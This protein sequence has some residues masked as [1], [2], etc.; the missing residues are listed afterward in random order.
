MN[1]FIKAAVISII[2]AALTIILKVITTTEI[3]DYS[4][5]IDWDVVNEMQYKEAQH[6]LEKNTITITGIS[7]FTEQVTQPAHWPYFLKDLLYIA[8][9]YL[10][11]LIALLFWV[12]KNNKSNK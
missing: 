1:S 6:Y 11:S 10:L 8:T 7:A 12:T 4:K 2:A 5:N 9:G 3:Q